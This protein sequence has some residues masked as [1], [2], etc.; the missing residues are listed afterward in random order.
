M[1]LYNM[2]IIFIAYP[3]TRMQTLYIGYLENPQYQE[4]NDTII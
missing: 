4:Y 1:Y 3:A 2:Y